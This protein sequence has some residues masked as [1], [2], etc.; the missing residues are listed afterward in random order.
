MNHR[1]CRDDTGSVTVAGVSV[2]L[3]VVALALVI[4]TGVAGM[5][6][7]HRASAAADLTALSAATVMQ[8]KGLE[9]ACG[10]AEEIAEA[11][12][13][14][15]DSCELVRGDDT[16]YGPSGGVGIGVTVVVAGTTASAAAGAVT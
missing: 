1:T 15:L 5:L 9:E 4:G 16:D 6:Q 2:I 13:A 7:G 14:R 12:G 3:A 10:T 11:N 8:H